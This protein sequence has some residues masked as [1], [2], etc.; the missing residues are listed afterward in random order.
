[1]K[2]TLAIIL[3]LM[4]IMSSAFTTTAFAVEDEEKIYCDATLD[5]DFEDDNILVMFTN[6]ASLKF[7]TYTADDFSEIGATEVIDLTAK[8]ADY[9]KYQL[10]AMENGMV[11]PEEVLIAASEFHQVLQIELDKNDKQNVLDAV[12]TVEQ[13]D[14]VLLAQPNFLYPIDDPT[15]YYDING[16][17]V[18]DINDATYLQMYLA[19]FESAPID[20][21]DY[22]E[23]ATADC[24]CD[25]II[26]VN[27]AT[28]LQ[29]IIAGYDIWF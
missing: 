1:M 25:G 9:L 12:H 15:E 10:D 17:G 22:N 16:D 24:N 8:I 13:R 28:T 26:D 2:K 23:F 11:I 19:G 7:L 21:D 29:M 18:T 3:A 6:E 14:D 4:L 20:E 27:D 5:D